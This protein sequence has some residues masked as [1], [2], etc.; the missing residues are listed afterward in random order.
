MSTQLIELIILFAIAAFVLFRLKSVIGTRTGYE[1]PPDYLSR[2]GAAAEARARVR[3]L[4]AEEDEDEAPE[5]LRRA[6]PETR[7]AIEAMR[8]ADPDFSL[9]RFIEGARA[10][11]EMI[12]MA[13]EAGD[14]DTLRSLL[15]PEVFEAFDAV[16]R[17]REARGLHVDARFIGIR[18][19]ALEGASF[20]PSTREAEITLRFVGEMITAVRDAEG[21]II[22]GDP[23]EIRR[24]T[25]VWTFGR[26]L[27]SPDPTWLL[28]ATGA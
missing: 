10:A 7:A 1:A 12:L 3:P 11:Y 21:R 28:I 9:S 22:E 8:R 18:D 13:Y 23:N 16:I 2:E 19:L 25:D 17:E 26:R 24:Q 15:A 5:L 6:S 4:P 27:G 20:D 14:R